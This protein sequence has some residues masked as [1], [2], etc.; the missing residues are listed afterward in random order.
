MSETFELA[1][2]GA[3][4]AGLEA[5]LS[6]SAAGVSTALVDSAPQ[7]GG[8][9][10][11]P[12]PAAFKSAQKTGAEKEGAAL[13]ERLAASSVTCIFDALVWGIFKE[14]NGEGWV[15][16]LYGPDAPKRLHARKLILANGAYDTP[17]AFPGWTLPGVITCGAALTLLKNQRVAPFRRALLTGS[18]PLLL[19]AAAHLVDA[20]VEVA[21]VCEA[22][23]L[24]P[25]AIFYA[26]TMLREWHRLEEGAQYLATLLRARAPYKLGWCVVEARGEAQVEEAVIARLDQNGV[27]LPGTQQ[28]L[29]VDGVVCGYGLTPN[30]GLARMIG[31]QFEYRPERGAWVARRDETLQ[32]NLPGVYLAGDGSEVNGAENARLEGRVAGS[33]V[34]LETGHLR[35]READEFFRKARP[36]LAQGRRYGHMLAEIFPIKPGLISLAHDDTLICRCE[37]ITL[38]EVKAAVAAGARTLG[39]VKMITRTGMGNCQGRTCERAVAGALLQ[40]LAGQPATPTSVGTFTTRPPLHPLPLGAFLEPEERS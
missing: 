30:H 18:G 27:P 10:A 8:Q 34:A 33:A 12:L 21:G 15:V 38:G 2:I 39:E 9:Y 32:T 11:K 6:A 29:K 22:N 19:S 5:A 3:G 24:K 40:Q 13:I 7:A 1:V 26:P 16:C 31:C 25:Q 35:Q 14:E 20:G 37:E 28:S 4:P 23:R 36:A 17:V